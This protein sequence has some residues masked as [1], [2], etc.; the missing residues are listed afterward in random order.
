[1][2]VHTDVSY[3]YFAPFN[4]TLSVFWIIVAVVI[5]LNQ[6]SRNYEYIFMYQ[7][8]LALCNSPKAN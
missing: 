7:Q 6:P 1:M 5:Q 4:L 8:P 3:V 2:S